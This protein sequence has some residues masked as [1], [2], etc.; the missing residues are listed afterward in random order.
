VIP[1]H[2]DPAHARIGL[3]GR[4]GLTLRRLAWLREAGAEPD[5]WSDAPS[6]E[7]LGAAPKLEARFPGLGEIARY[8]AIWI[9]DLA[10]AEAAPLA[11]AARDAHV[12]INVED[13]SAL[14]DFHTPAIVRRGKLTISAGTGGA[15]PAVARAVRER[16]DEAF[17]PGWGEA[18]DDIANARATLRRDGVSA[19]A[20]AADARQRL[21]ARGLI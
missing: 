19:E 18:I 9:A 21:S 5:V 16:L 1:I 12:L 15:S 7:L 2:L 3:I 13:Q 6:A 14:C 4:D 8:H 20:L 10:P 11:G 17:G